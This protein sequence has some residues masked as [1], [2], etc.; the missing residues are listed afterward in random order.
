MEEAGDER[1]P[2]PHPS[3]LMEHHSEQLD[4][5][6]ALEA[7]F[8]AD[9][10]LDSPPTPSDASTSGSPS[11]GARF[12]VSVQEGPARVRISFAHPPA[13]PSSAT[14]VSVLALA[15]VSAPQRRLLQD[16]LASA[17]RACAPEPAG[18]AVC[19]AARE[20]LASAGACAGDEG[21]DDDD[22]AGRFETI[23]AAAATAVE[24]VAAKAL[25]TPVTLESF[26]EWARGFREERERGRGKVEVAGGK[27]TGR[28]MFEE[29]MVDVDA[30]AE[31]WEL[32]ADAFEGADG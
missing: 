13:Y 22:G 16:L 12:R 5:I 20:W 10:T 7:I 2:D 29:K 15:G 3:L 23:D 4:E 9:F 6:E 11:E 27:M 31:L 21:G 24:R 25:G 14:C 1:A 18:W 19:D 32:E 17:A 30:D 26:A 8:D 28:A